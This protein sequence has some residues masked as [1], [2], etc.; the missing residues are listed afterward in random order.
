MSHKVRLSVIVVSVAFLANAGAG[1][2]EPPVALYGTITIDGVPATAGDN[3]T[4]IARVEGV[5]QP[6]GIYQMCEDPVAGDQYI[7]QIRVES[8]AD[9]AT[10]SEDAAVVGQTAVVSVQD[11]DSGIVRRA[12]QVEISSR[13]MLVFQDLSVTSVLGDCANGDGSLG[14]A[15]FSEFAGCITGVGGVFVAHCACADLDQ[16]GDVD[17]RDFSHFQ[18]AFNGD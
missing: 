2:P 16:D 18:V 3:V 15:D 11:D 8:L 14:L 1:I 6:V 17:L 10:Q 7:L 5:P 9:G 12:G 13:G 4:V